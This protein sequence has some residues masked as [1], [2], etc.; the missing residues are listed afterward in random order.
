[1]FVK[2]TLSLL[3]IGCL[4]AGF[5]VLP[6]SAETAPLTT[7]AFDEQ[8]KYSTT[9]SNLNGWGLAFSFT[10][11]A[12][13]VKKTPAGY[14]KLDE[15]SL[16]YAGESCKITRIG[17][18]VTHLAGVG[19][20]DTRMTRE[21]AVGRKQMKDVKITRMYRATA[22][23][24]TFAVRVVNIPYERESDL[25]YVRPYVEVMCQGEKVTLY[26]ATDSASYADKVS[27][28][29]VYTPFYG[30]DVDGK[31]RLFV[32]DTAVLEQTLYLEI[33]DELDDWMVLPNDESSITLGF[34]DAAGNSLGTEKFMLPEL[35][36]HNASE[37]FTIEL[38]EGTAEVKIVSAQI[39]YWSNWE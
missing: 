36:Q 1:M 12:T 13:E 29:T 5:A 6:V 16:E 33:Q 26:G 4:L 11:N 10:L 14:T 39:R 27:E 28:S 9:D 38:P 31:G 17:A 19:G 22:S 37:V 8:V 23:S 30:S 34:F 24:C 20:D 18:V 7:D 2:K 32:G 35:S 15:A 25:L 3:L 21:F